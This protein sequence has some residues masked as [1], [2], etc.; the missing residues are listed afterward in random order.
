MGKIYSALGLMSGTSMDGIDASITQS[1]GENNFKAIYNKYFEYNKDLF[2]NLINLRDKINYSKD[3]DKMS[4]EIIALEK[5]IT[6]FHAQIS[7][8]IILKSGL[9]IDF[10]GFH[11]QTV[12]HNVEEKISK[13]LGDA[14]LLSQITK[15]KV[16]YSFRQNDLDNGGEGAPLT[17]IYHKLLVKLLVKKKK[18]KTPIIILNIGGI[19]NKTLI[20]SSYEMSSLDIGPGNCL[21]DKWIRVNSDKNYDKDGDIAKSGRVDKFIL[22]QSLDNFYN[23]SISKKKSFDINDF[24]IFFARG[25]SLENGAATITE[26]TADILSK[27]LLDND[28]YVCGGGRKN[29]FLLE[30]IQNKIQNKITDI[31]ELGID[32]S[33][34]ESQAFGYLAIRSFLKLPISFP[35][36]TG[37]KEQ[38]SGGIL[39]KNY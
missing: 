13:Q 37:C 34:I 35:E 23:N 28:I 22:E 24:D 8:K 20:G 33:F 2:R 14:N 17:P 27:N 18:I 9:D 6:L 19:A 39:I 3:I 31:D 25:L 16:V 11:G 12:F 4:N 32:G 38:C 29:K 10:I 5:E 15:K 30:S 1:D 26:F 36:T 7:N 21:I